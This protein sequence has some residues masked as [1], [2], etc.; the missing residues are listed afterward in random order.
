MPTPK[1]PQPAADALN[2]HLDEVGTDASAWTPEDRSEY[3]RLSD[4]TMREQADQR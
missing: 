2:K 1:T 4:A 3:H